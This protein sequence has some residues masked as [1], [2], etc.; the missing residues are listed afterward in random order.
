MTTP[1]L[2]ASLTLYLVFECKFLNNSS[3]VLFFVFSLNTYLGWISSLKFLASSFIWY[4][5]SIIIFLNV[6]SELTISGSILITIALYFFANCWIPS[7]NCFNTSILWI[8]QT[9]PLAEYIMF[10]KIGIFLIHTISDPII[11]PELS[12]ASITSCFQLIFTFAHSSD[13]WKLH[14]SC[15][16]K[17]SVYS[18]SEFSSVTNLISFF[19]S[20][21]NYDCLYYLFLLKLLTL[22]YKWLF[23]SIFFVNFFIAIL[24]EMVYLI[25]YLFHYIYIGFSLNPLFRI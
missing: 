15:V 23:I 13:C 19:I 6:S 25:Y 5:K 24:L 20:L 3:S 2:V 4:P 14:L 21:S 16:S 22:Y 12:S 18:L 7:D 17:N 10:P 8:S 9:G 11:F 1:F